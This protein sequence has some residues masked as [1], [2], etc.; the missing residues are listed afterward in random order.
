MTVV[1]LLARA[2][3]TSRTVTGFLVG[4]AGG[5]VAIALAL[6]RSPLAPLISAVLPI[7]VMAALSAVRGRAVWTGLGLRRAGLRFWPTALLVPAAVALFAFGTASALGLV[8]RGTA[9]WST[10][11]V[12][13]LTG[14]TFGAL[15]V[16]PEELGWRGFLLPRLQQLT[17]ARTGALLTGLGH[18]VVHLPLVIWTSTYNPD[19]NRWV[20]APLMLVTITAAG[21]FYA[22]L[23]D[24]SGSIWPATIAHGMG[25]ALLTAVLATGL[26]DGGLA[27][28][29]GEGGLATATATSTVAVICLV[30]SKTWRRLQPVSTGTP[31]KRPTYTV[32]KP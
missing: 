12:S 29:A 31:A 10:V 20:V 32:K 2:S 18:A 11:L 17:S 1:E 13:A 22:W 6:P 14:S 28:V 23:R 5:S 3:S 9:A 4:V 21:V 30:G 19:G 27:L 15:L 25:N 24:V 7:A 26:S 8:D 16:L